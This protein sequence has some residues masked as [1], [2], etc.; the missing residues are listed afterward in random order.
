MKIGSKRNLTTLLSL[1]LLTS[2]VR[3]EDK[4]ALKDE[5]EKV[6]YG[7]G[8]NI[9][10]NLKRQSYDVDVDLIAKAMKDVLGGKETLLTEQQAQ[11]VLTAYQKELRAKQEE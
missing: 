7:I 11:E 2:L 1:A 3:A 5:K 6:S 4:P 9:G 10:N 8:M